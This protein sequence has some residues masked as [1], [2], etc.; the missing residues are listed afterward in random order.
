MAEQQS[1]PDPSVPARWLTPGVQGIGLA[2]LLADLG[3]EVPTSLLPSF[4]TVSLGAP[5]A[6]LGLIE[7][8]ADCAAGLSRFG[9]GALADDPERRR[10]SAV[11]GYTS[12][13]VFSSL[14]GVAV[15]VWQVA[16]FRIL[17]WAARGLR[18]P[19][20][21]ALLADVVP[22]K[23]YGRAYGFERSMDNL[24]AIGGPLLALALVALLNVRTAMLISVVPGLLATLAIIYAIRH[25]PRPTERVRQPL[26][27]RVRP[28]LHGRLGRFMTG[29]ACFELGNVAA[30]LL[31]LRA[32]DVFA[33][34]RSH[35]EATQLALLLYA[36]HNLAATVI[37]VPAG[38]AG[39][40]HGTFPILVVGVLLFLIAYLGLAIAGIPLLIMAFIAAGLAIGCIET[41][42]H[43]AVATF[44]PIDL[45]GSAFGLLATVQSF[46]NLAASAAAGLLWSTVSAT[47]AFLYLAA[48]MVAALVAF[49]LSS[50][51]PEHQDTTGV[52]AAA[53]NAES[54]APS[55]SCCV[56][57]KVF[58]SVKVVA[59]AGKLK[60]EV[61]GVPPFVSKKSSWICSSISAA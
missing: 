41:A 13:A 17:A 11:S 1:P 57:M 45:R 24:G 54:N 49:T 19:A 53:M 18:V 27:I 59:P 20:R 52:V 43:A 44:A 4:L 12:T 33:S 31:I 21:N 34:G 2:S 28:V 22:A 35:S 60:V 16:I 7:G 51:R 50:H 58:R 40:R 42:Q 9:S 46:G 55:S 26:R 14:I 38:R 29:V 8:L 37:S 61:S 32:V 23:A 5:A 10:T 39:D 25:T 15:A 6:A 56:E 47:V 48:W 36:L 30:T 3:H